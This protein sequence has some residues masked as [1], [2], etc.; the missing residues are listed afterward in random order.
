[1]LVTAVASAFLDNVTTMLLMIP[2][3]IQIAVTLKIN[4]IALL[5]PEVF[6]SNIGGTATLIGDPPNILIG[7]YAKLSFVD[8]VMNLTVI[9]AICM[10]VTIIYYVYWYKKSYLKAEVKDTA[11][12]IE[13]LRQEYRIT[14]KKLLLFSLGFLAFTIFLF[15]IHGV[16]HME[17]SVA[18]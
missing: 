9:V 16:L 3:T 5:I 7:S 11:L 4:P 10:V 13:Y 14:N 2:V 12:T 15:I 8:F 6:A 18:A 17:P 1:M